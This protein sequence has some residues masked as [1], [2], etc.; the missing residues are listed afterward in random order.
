MYGVKYFIIA[1][2]DKNTIEIFELTD[3]KYKQTSDN[4]AGTS[5]PIKLEVEAE[6]YSDRTNVKLELNDVKTSFFTLAKTRDEVAAEV[7]KIYQLDKSLILKVLDL[8]VEDG[9]SVEEDNPKKD[10]N[11]KGENEDEDED[12]DEDSRNN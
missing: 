9:S 3:N 1:D 5:T 11:N 4:S 10:K 7:A 12:D 6:V 2:C 8:E